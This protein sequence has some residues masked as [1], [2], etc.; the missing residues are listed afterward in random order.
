MVLL[1]FIKSIK[2]LSIASTFA[3][4]LQLVALGLVVY[5]L[6]TDIPPVDSR[7]KAIG[8]KIPLFFSTTVFSFEVIKVVSNSIRAQNSIKF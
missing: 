3:N 2:Q 5:N 4:L 7:T 8:T 6:V 1:S